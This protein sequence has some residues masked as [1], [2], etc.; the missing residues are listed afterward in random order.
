MDETIRIRQRTDTFVN[1]EISAVPMRSNLIPVWN[2]L[3][4]FYNT[5]LQVIL[6]A[7]G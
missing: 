7:I 6:F 1:T 2:A 4:R 5:F 3:M